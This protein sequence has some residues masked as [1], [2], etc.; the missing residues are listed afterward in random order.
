MAL[1]DPPKSGDTVWSTP[2]GELHCWQLAP[3]SFVVKMSGHLEKELARRFAADF[4][5]AHPGS[6]DAIFFDGG[7]MS[8]YDSAFR[9]GMTEW[10]MGVKKRTKTLH[11]W[12]QS[13]L[14]QMGVAV[15]NLALGGVLRVHATRAAMEDAARAAVGKTA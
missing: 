7:E 4:D 9:V 14:V 1:L 5:R 6:L 2:R 15:A 12:V 13:K 8:G 11:V 3:G 10:A